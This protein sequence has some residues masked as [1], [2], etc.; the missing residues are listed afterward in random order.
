MNNLWMLSCVEYGPVHPEARVLRL[1]A[2]AGHGP[3]LALFGKLSAQCLHVLPRVQL[4][5]LKFQVVC[6]PYDFVDALPAEHADRSK[7][8]ACS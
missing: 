2:D 7:A 5:G 4:D 6:Q 1:I 3:N 8:M